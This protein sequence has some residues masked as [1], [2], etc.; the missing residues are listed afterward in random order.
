MFRQKINQEVVALPKISVVK[1]E[2]HISLKH[3]ISFVVVFGALGSYLLYSSF[4]AQAVVTNLGSTQMTLPAG[5]FTFNASQ[6]ASGKAVVFKQPGTATGTV[7]IPS[8]ASVSS[9]SV[10]ARAIDCANWPH[11]TITVDGKAAIPLTQ[12]TSSSWTSYSDN[13]TLASG[14]HSVSLVTGD[15][16]GQTTGSCSRYLFLDTITFYGIPPPPVPTLAFS[17]SPKTVSTGSSSTLTWTSTN[18][19]SCTASGAWSGTKPISGSAS[20]GALHNNSTYSLN[21]TGAGGSAG[22]SVGV[23]IQKYNVVSY[24]ADPTGQ[25]DS[26]VAIRTAIAAAEMSA[27]NTVWFPSGTYD[28]K[29]NDGKRVDI[30]VSGPYPITIAGENQTTTKIIEGIGDNPHNLPQCVTS[31]IPKETFQINSNN[32]GTVDNSIFTGLT[33]DNQLCNAGTALVANGNHITI[34][35]SHF[36][37]AQRADTFGIRLV[38]SCHRSTTGGGVTG[39]I[40]TG[41]TVKDITINGLGDAGNADLDF[42]C[43]QNGTLNNITDTGWGLAFYLDSNITVTN[44]TFA[45]GT[46]ENKP[47]GWYIT[48]PSQNI[49]ITNFTSTGNGGVISSAYGYNTSGVTINNEHMS[50]IGNSMVI[51]YA[52]NTK[53]NGSSLGQLKLDTSDTGVTAVGSSINA[54]VCSNPPPSGLNGLSCP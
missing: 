2:H 25:K 20:T 41:N 54:V 29:D 52:T 35:N 47:P 21:C 4:A 46:V 12:V 11:L 10:R 50:Q 44:V 15:H 27:G 49:T 28:L 38:S 33:V 36:L 17:A 24:G 31:T 18:A 14:S 23:T 48:G 34:E 5:A 16:V 9:M 43:Q 53:I 51:N 37:G 39:N 45:P 6:T 7:T 22:Q 8:G 26:T 40:N 42:S 3:L 13:V 1:S 30:N 19:T 32:V